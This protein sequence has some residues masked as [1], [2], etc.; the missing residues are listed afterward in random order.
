VDVNPPP[1]PEI[2]KG[3]NDRFNANKFEE[4]MFMYLSSLD[5]HM[6]VA[7]FDL[8]NDDTAFF[9]ISNMLTED[10]DLYLIQNL[11]SGASFHISVPKSDDGIFISNRKLYRFSYLEEGTQITVYELKSSDS[12]N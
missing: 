4:M 8:L 1:V 10:D 6:V 3:V 2:F 12:T 5:P 11:N 9:Y 7:I